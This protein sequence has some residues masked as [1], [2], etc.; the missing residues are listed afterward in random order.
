MTNE[1]TVISAC[2]DEPV[3]KVLAESDAAQK[4]AATLK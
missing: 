1:K 3:K 2:F 4:L